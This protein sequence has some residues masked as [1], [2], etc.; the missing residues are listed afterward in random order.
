LRQLVHVAFRVA[1]EMGAEF[2]SALD[3]AREIAGRCVTDNLFDRHI[4]PLFL[5]A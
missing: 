2:T 3:D 5:G 1:A 4:R